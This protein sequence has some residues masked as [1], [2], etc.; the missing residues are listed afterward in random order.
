M[1]LSINQTGTLSGCHLAH[2][3]P[4]LTGGLAAYAKL[5]I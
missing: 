5:A 2:F 1:A 4:P 3:P